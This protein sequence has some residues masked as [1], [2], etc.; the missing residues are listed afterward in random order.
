MWW[1]IYWVLFFVKQ[2]TTCKQLLIFQFIV[3]WETF[4]AW[5]T[6]FACRIFQFWICV[7]D[8]IPKKVYYKEAKQLILILVLGSLMSVFYLCYLYFQILNSFV[9]VL[10]LGFGYYI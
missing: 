9:Y 5:W 6:G 7:Q 3:H 2:Y 8:I 1:L 10:I 4:F